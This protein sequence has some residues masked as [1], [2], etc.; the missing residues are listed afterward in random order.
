MPRGGGR[1]KVQSGAQSFLLTGHRHPGLDLQFRRNG[2]EDGT[3]A[4]QQQALHPAAKAPRSIAASHLARATG[5]PHTTIGGETF[6][7]VGLFVYFATI[8]FIVIVYSSVVIVRS[9]VRKKRNNR[10]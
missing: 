6:P 1:T 5:R 3:E 7:P 10:L 4:L 8:N 2:V 9:G